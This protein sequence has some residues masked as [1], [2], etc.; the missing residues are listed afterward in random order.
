M[1][2]LQRF[3][4][5][6]RVHRAGGVDRLQRKQNA[7]LGIDRK[8]VERGRGQFPGG[9]GPAFGL[10]GDGRPAG[11][12]AKIKRNERHQKGDAQRGREPAGTLA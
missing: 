3:R 11:L 7:A 2:G 10:R 9:G 4:E 8:V 5:D 6:G 1:Q 12:G